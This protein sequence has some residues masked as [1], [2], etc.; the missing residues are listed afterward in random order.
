MRCLK[1]F[2]FCLSFVGKIY[3][4]RLHHQTLSS[5]GKSSVLS[6]GFKV[7]QSIGQT[8]VIGNFKTSSFLIGQGFIQSK[9]GF[10]NS[11][12]PPSLLEVKT[13]PNPFVSEIHFK[14]SSEVTS[15]VVLCVFDNRGRLVY[16]TVKIPVDLVITITDLYLSEGTYIVKLT[17]TNL[18][19]TTQILS[20]R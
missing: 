2:L 1:I 16:K 8:S 4:Q 6:N 7:N 14:L 17:G 11:V 19:Y 10:Q 5:Q 9:Q 12:L 20:T 13:Y 15:P 18:N 3:S